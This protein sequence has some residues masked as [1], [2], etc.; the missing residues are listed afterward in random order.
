MLSSVWPITS[1]TK[2]CARP[3]AVEDAAQ[4][5]RDDHRRH[6]DRQQDQDA[7]RLLAAEREAAERIGRRQ[8]Q[9]EGHDRDDRREDEARADGAARSREKVKTYSHCASERL[10]GSTA[11]GDQGSSGFTSDHM[12]AM[13]S[14][15]AG[16]HQQQRDDEQ[17]DEVP[18]S[19]SRRRRRQA[20]AW[21]ASA[22]HRAD[23][24]DG[25]RRARIDRDEEQRGDDDD[26][27][28]AGGRAP[29]AAA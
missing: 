2:V 23:P 5:H 18:R 17:R 13:K 4:E 26:H 9:D 28:D 15:T 1:P 29:V 24:C 22:R 10:G 6:D 20:R 8:R 7:Q 3:K 11:G 25:A 14:G 12:T 19:S 27:A 21:R 16:P